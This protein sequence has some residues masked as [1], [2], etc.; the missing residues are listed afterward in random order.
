MEKRY[1]ALRAIGSIYK[2]VGII[3][4]AVTVLLTIGIC[5]FSLL[6]GA[7]L[8][9][10]MSYYGSSS[11]GFFSGLVAGVLIGIIN[12]VYGGLGALLIYGAGEMI[13][14]FISIEENTRK[15]TAL[16]EQQVHPQNQ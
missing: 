14:V 10:A 4:G 6:G 13:Y 12:L 5:L 2:T 1:K 9:S 11:G 7:A 16:F 15:T 8:D 3:I